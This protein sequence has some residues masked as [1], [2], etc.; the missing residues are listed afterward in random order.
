MERKESFQCPHCRTK[1]PFFFVAKIKNDHEF[2]CPN[3]G[4]TLVPEKT[5][6]F[7]WGYVLGFL[8]FVVPGQI[9]LYLYDDFV[10]AFMASTI[11]ALTAIFLI[12]VY[13]YSNTSLNKSI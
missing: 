3:C 5:K 8:A 11:C 4:E 6:S 9:L 13:I 10:L 1:L 2:E 7:L 12:A